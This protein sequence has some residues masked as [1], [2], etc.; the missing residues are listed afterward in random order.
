MSL[1]ETP[2]PFNTLSSLWRPA[3]SVTAS[4]DETHKFLIGTTLCRGHTEHTW[5]AY[6]CLMLLAPYFRVL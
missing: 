6:L 3:P 2:S 1:G 4:E 5:G